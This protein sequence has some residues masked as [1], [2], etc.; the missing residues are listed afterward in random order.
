MDIP[1]SSGWPSG[2]GGGV[3]RWPV[4]RGVNGLGSLAQVETG[5]FLWSFG[6]STV[7]CPCLGSFSRKTPG[8]SCIAGAPCFCACLGGDLSEM[9][10][11]LSR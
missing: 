8:P 11:N 3:W 1:G 7:Q 5:T 10:S 4:G 6:L 2:G 9:E